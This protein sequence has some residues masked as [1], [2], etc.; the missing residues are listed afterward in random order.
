MVVRLSVFEQGALLFAEVEGATT[1]AHSL[2]SFLK[3]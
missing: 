3:T 1:M 2:V